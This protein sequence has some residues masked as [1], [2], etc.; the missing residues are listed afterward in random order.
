MENY[1]IVIVGAGPAGLMAARKAGEK[2]V[3]VLLVEKQ[4]MLGVKACGEAVSTRTI[5]DAEIQPSQKFISNK[6]RGAFIYAPDEKKRVEIF[7]EEL[8]QGYIL[9]KPAFL[10]CSTA[11]IN[12]LRVAFPPIFIIWSSLAVSNPRRMVLKPD[13][14]IR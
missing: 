12:S 5:T 1:D 8:G 4:A 6:V 3:R 11:L 10:R 13:W 9:E 7:S 14:N 2:N